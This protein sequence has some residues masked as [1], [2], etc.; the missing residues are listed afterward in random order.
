MIN[1]ELLFTYCLVE[2]YLRLDSEMNIKLA[3]IITNILIS[4]PTIDGSISGKFTL[5][6]IHNILED[7]SKEANLIKSP[8]C[9]EEQI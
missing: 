8:Y 6:R 9:H 3:K 2:N 7:T 1:A 4:G 5:K